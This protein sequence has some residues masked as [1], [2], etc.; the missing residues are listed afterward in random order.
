MRAALLPEDAARFDRQ[1][2][3]AMARATR[4][5]DLTEVHRTLDDWRRVAWVTTTTGADRYRTVLADA[6][7]RLRTGDRHPGAVPWTQLEVELGLPG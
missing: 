1:W 5:L 7:R 4:D 3:D 2:Q 6:D